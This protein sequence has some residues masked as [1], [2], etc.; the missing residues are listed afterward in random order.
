VV[1]DSGRYPAVRS[2]AATSSADAG[3][4]AGVGKV[5]RKVMAKYRV[6]PGTCWPVLAC[7]GKSR[8][9]GRFAGQREPPMRPGDALFGYV[10]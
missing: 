6:L 9:Y 4:E 5:A 10:R 7:A 2:P 8:V 3:M 1:D